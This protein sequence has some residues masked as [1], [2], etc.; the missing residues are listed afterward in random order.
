MIGRDAS[1]S[2]V[3]REFLYSGYVAHDQVIRLN[4]LGFHDGG[5]PLSHGNFQLRAEEIT[6]LL[7]QATADFLKTRES[8][9]ML[10]C[11]TLDVKRLSRVGKLDA[12]FLKASKYL[13]VDRFLN[14][15]INAIV[16]VGHKIDNLK[17]QR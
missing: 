15:H 7:L 6:R 14:I 1:R 3:I 5:D 11:F 16:G 8:L 10:L 2:P 4:G 17:V 13:L 9:L 12:F